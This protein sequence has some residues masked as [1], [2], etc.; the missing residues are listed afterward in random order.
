MRIRFADCLAQ[1]S[2]LLVSRLSP[3]TLMVQQEGLFKIDKSTGPAYVN[4]MGGNSNF[5]ARRAASL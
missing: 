3:M 5:N 2:C 1:S 4:A